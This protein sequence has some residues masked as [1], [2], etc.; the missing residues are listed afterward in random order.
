[1]ASETEPIGSTATLTDNSFVYEGYSFSDWNTAANGS[2]T[3]YLN[4]ATFD[5]TASITLYAQWAAQFEGSSDANW[6]G[7]VL[8]SNSAIFTE[9]SAQWTVPKLNCADTPNSESATWVGTGGVT[10]SN[11]DSSGTL[12]QTGTEDNCVDGVQ[13]DSGVFELF[14]ST[15]NYAE[16]FNDFP[17]SPGNVINAEVSE[18]TSGQWATFVENLTTGLEGVFGVGLGW[19]VETIASHT[20]VGSLQGIASGTSYSGAYSAEWI[21]EDPTEASAGSLFSMSNFGTISLTDI[22]TSLP[23][24]WTL[25]NTDADEIVQNGTTLSVPAPVVNDG[26]TVTY[27]GP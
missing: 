8:P 12:L 13:Q 5:F 20:V 10:W 7:Y 23:A 24:G 18:N 19:E 15:P 11:G 1:M 14:P 25:P 6:S 4:G 22:E 9:V 17:V 2:G 3:S 27:T 21:V 16:T 26:F